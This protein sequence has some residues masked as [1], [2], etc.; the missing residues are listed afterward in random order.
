MFSIS[1]EFKELLKMDNVYASTARKLTLNFYNDSVPDDTS[2]AT[3]DYVIQN[4]QIS[5]ES[6]AITESLCDE[7]NLVFGKCNASQLEIT[8]LDVLIDL[9]DKEF[10]V[11]LEVG[12]HSMPLGI[13]RVESFVRQSDRRM[14]KIVAYDRMRNFNVD[15]AEWYHGLTFPISLK[16]FR[17]S[18]CDYV[19]VFQV[20]TTLPMD[21]M[22]IS[23][24]IDPQQLSGLDV[25]QAICEIN[26]CFGHIDRLGRF[27]YIEL[28]VSSL[29]PADDLYPDD[30]LFPSNLRDSENTEFLT[31]YKSSETTYEDYVTEYIERVQIR[32]EEGDIGAS[33][34]D[35]KNCYVV[36]G[37]FLVYG[38]SSDELIQIA[39]EIYDRIRLISYR[40]CKIVSPALLWVEPGDGLICY[41]TDDVIETYCFKRTLKG[42]Q[43]M[44]DIF[45][46]DGLIET[47]E[48][49]GIQTQIIQLEGKALIL[50][51]SIEEVSATMSDLKNNTESQFKITAA[52]IAAEVE[53]AKESESELSVKADAISLNVANLQESTAAQFKVLSNEISLKVS[54]GGVSAQLSVETDGITITGNRLKVNATN[55]TISADG[56]LSC[57]NGTFSGK[58]T[59]TSGKIGGFTLSGSTL[60]AS[61]SAKIDF[62]SFYL[63]T[64]GM[65]FEGVEISEDGISPGSIGNR[66]THIWET[67]TGDLY[68]NELY[69]DQPWWEGW[70]V[71]ETVQE[72]WEYV[73]GGGWNPCGSDDCGDDCDCIGDSSC[74]CEE[75]DCDGSCEVECDC[76]G[77]CSDSC[78]SP[79]VC[80]GDCDG[81]AEGPGCV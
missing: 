6:L 36:E 73:H 72:L 38:K 50:K 28:A 48:N 2:S 71:T 61:S 18:L 51:T 16:D 77:D 8:V 11:I 44:T 62:D 56:T 69:I 66:Y 4:S 41:T 31:Y 80:S 64:D 75:E 57:T 81:G 30:E 63:D 17:D 24:T 46:A 78:D 52:E 25:I 7:E 9:T 58:V 39:A 3:P 13:F 33:Y 43:G 19:G 15:V 10:E 27:K 49:F 34:G 22:L 45:E 21:E 37:N 40:P 55:L 76:G 65:W 20:D 70:S 14:K 60:T 59:A 42:I 26:G 5:S 29:F 68:V 79:T 1:D 67:D 23:E 12:E 53:R 35:G 74:G 47:E 54:K 32:Q